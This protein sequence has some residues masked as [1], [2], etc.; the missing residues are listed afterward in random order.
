MKKTIKYAYKQTIPV[1]VGYIFMGIAFGVLLSREG[2][3]PLWAFCASTFIYAGS[4]QF[5]LV[6][7]LH[8]AAPLIT[9]AIM[10][11]LVQCRHIFY[12]LG[13]I[14]KFKRMGIKCPY[15][16]H[17]MTDETYSLLCSVKYPPDIDED[18]CSFYI[19]LFD[20]IYWILGGVIGALI[21]EIIPLDFTGIDFSM[22][23]LFIVIFI[24][25][26]REM[27]SH[28]PAVIGLCSSALFLILLGSDNFLLPSL[29]LT[30]GLLCVLKKRIKNEISD[31]SAEKEEN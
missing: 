26:W 23:A 22:T 13:F 30:V 9:V 14:D 10:T 8:D 19:S 1:A 24:N 15:M 29:L 3:N 25:Q 18:K 20:H 11:F 12:G 4:M 7:L 16:I 31:A 17:A 28:I 6:S 21:G 27:T 2:Y 5:V